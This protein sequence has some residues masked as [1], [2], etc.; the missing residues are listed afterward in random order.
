MAK[1]SE[2]Y[3]PSEFEYLHIKIEDNENENI[4]EHFPLICKFVENKKNGENVLFHC[5]EGKNFIFY[6]LFLFFIFIFLLLFLFLFFIL[7]VSRSASALIS[8]LIYRKNNRLNLEESLQLL[9]SKRSIVNPNNGFI[10][11]IKEW[12]KKHP[13]K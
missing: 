12:E 2:C 1:E 3:F 5:M 7:G 11:Q 9:K 8:Y 4:I 10:E 6:F 13:K